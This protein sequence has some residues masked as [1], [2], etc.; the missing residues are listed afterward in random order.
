MLIGIDATLLLSTPESVNNH[1][2]LTRSG[3]R[4]RKRQRR[5]GQKGNDL[6]S[7]IILRYIV[8]YR[9]YKKPCLNVIYRCYGCFVTTCTCSSCS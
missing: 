3:D 8:D 1:T 9:C 6:I 2:A 7:A 4:A 5:M